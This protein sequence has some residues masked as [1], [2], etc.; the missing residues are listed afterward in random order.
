MKMKD[1]MELELGKSKKTA[2]KSKSKSTAGGSTM[3]TS[4][5]LNNSTDATA[6][7]SDETSTAAE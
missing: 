2:Y 4:G 3:M 1:T 5:T 7:T 6:T